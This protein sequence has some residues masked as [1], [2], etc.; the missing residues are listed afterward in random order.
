MGARAPAHSL[1]GKVPTV[2]DSRNAEWKEVAKKRRR[3]G[4][5]HEW[6]AL[7]ARP[8]MEEKRQS[9][10]NYAQDYAVVNENLECTKL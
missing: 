4:Q 6:Y 9:K 8:Y 1:A 2:P 5:A 7:R 3:H 10:N